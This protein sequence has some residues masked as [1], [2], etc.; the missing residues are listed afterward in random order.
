MSQ[1]SR[2]AQSERS[3]S[4]RLAREVPW[5]LPVRGMFKDARSVEINGSMAEVLD[6]WKSNGVSL[7][8]R[9]GYAQ[10]DTSFAKQRIPYDFGDE[11]KYISITETD[12]SCD[13]ISIVRDFPNPV[14]S[15]EISSNTIM[16]DGAGDILRFNGT[17]FVNSGFT[18]DSGKP[19]SEFNGV[20]SHH[21][22]I[23]A[24]DDSELAFYYG[25]VG[26]V[27]GE[28]TRY[29]LDRLGN[30]KGKVMIVTSMTLNAAHGMNDILA[31][32]TTAGMIV[33]YEGLNP[34][35][36][37]DWRLL[38]R[39][40]TGAPVSKFALEAFGSDL[41]VLTARGI[42]SV[43]ETLAKGVFA[44]ASS[45][46]SPISDMI[47]ADVKANRSA[48]GWQMVS[49][50]DGTEII[51]NVP[52]DGGFKQ[53]VFDVEA[54]AWFTANYPATWWHDIDVRTDFTDTSGNLNR[55]INDGSD[56]GQPMVAT[57]YT[58]WIRLPNYSEIAYLIPTIIADGDLEVKVTVLTDHDQIDKDIAQ[59]Q[60]IITM[61]PDNPGKGVS[62]NEV[63]G[64]N[65]TGRVFQA[66]FEITGSGVSFENLTVGLV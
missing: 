52:Y 34:G 42:V 36:A 53:Y 54:N 65:A 14:S 57:F 15:T 28:L 50:T 2:A 63:I 49:R 29:P 21:D 44:L 64:V 13:G 3:R 38:G 26:A 32:V 51:V 60:Q 61:K 19:A 62:L 41:W 45:V 58:S 48:D 43:K 9:D 24:W 31:I 23:Y 12:A 66:R 11:P 10:V 16:A 55:L 22:R 56:N 1:I 20:F 37:N 17:A 33:L 40:K 4:R 27:T 46:A 18:T 30:I 47:V 5:P 7:E 6:N 25:D 39:I 35:D 59:S 8:M